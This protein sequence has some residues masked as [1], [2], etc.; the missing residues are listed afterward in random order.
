MPTSA[1]SLKGLMRPLKLNGKPHW[2]KSG[3]K[4]LSKVTMTSLPT[5][6]ASPMKHEKSAKNDTDNLL[7]LT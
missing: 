6:I 3:K 4:K 2:T 5:T 7:K 1:I